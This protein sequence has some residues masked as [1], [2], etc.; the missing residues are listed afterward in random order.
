VK[1]TSRKY[2]VTVRAR[3]CPSS[4]FCAGTL[5]SFAY[6]ECEARVS[7]LAWLFVAW[8]LSEEGVRLGGRKRPV[9]GGRVER[10]LSVGYQAR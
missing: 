1:C 9:G 10:G 2:L 4:C 6:K 8:G 5:A 3:G 7:V